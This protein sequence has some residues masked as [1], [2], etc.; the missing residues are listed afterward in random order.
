MVKIIQNIPKLEYFF[1]MKPSGLTI[2]KPLH[3][4]AGAIAN[5][6]QLYHERKT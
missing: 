6:C 5:I 2:G 3:D 4:G 1:K